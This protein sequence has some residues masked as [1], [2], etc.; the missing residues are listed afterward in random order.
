MVSEFSVIVPRR[1]DVSGASILWIRKIAE[2]MRISMLSYYGLPHFSSAVP[3]NALES[4]G[5]VSSLRS[6]VLVLR[7]GSMAKIAKLSVIQAIPVS[8]VYGSASPINQKRVHSSANSA[9]FTISKIV[10]RIG[11]VGMRRCPQNS[12]HLFDIITLNTS[13]KSFSERDVCDGRSYWDY[14]FTR[15]AILRRHRFSP[16]RFASFGL[17]AVRDDASIISRGGGF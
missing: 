15:T 14:G 2:K 9:T 12:L 16:V 17:Q 7:I 8:V 3:S 6:I 5:I 11:W 4:R 10:N 1:L 13:P